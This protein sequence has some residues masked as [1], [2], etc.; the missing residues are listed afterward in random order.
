MS[1][2]LCVDEMSIRNEMSATRGVMLLQGR[3][4]VREENEKEKTH[5]I[6]GKD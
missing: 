5:I 2:T 4:G 1:K 6:R 3:G